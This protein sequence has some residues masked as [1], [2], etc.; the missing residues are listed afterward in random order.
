MEYQDILST[1]TEIHEDDSIPR[2]IRT[3][4]RD[5]AEFLEKNQEKTNDLQIDKIIQALDDLGNDPNVPPYTRTQILGVI[6]NLESA[7]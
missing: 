4:I 3:R 5:A 7:R 2:N 1:L 6:S